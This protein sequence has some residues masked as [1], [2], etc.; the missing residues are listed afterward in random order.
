MSPGLISHQDNQNKG[1][2]V[3]AQVSEGRVATT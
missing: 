3:S 2:K 1:F